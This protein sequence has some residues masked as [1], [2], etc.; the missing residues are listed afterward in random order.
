MIVFDDITKVYARQLFRKKPYAIWNLS[1]NL[2]EGQTLGLIGANGA[3]KSTA[4]RLIMDFIRP[5]SGSITVRGKQPCDEATRQDIGYLPEIASFPSNLCLLDLIRF[6]AGTCGIK[7]NEMRE[8][9]EALM[10]QLGL[11]EHRRKRLHTYSKGMQQ[12]ANFVLALMNDPKL[13]ILDEPMSGLDPLGRGLIIDLIEK[14]K[15]QGKTILFCSH[16][17]GDVDRLADNLLVLHKGKELFSGFPAEFVRKEKTTNIEEAY[18]SLIKR[19]GESEH[20][21]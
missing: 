19:A 6:T 15:Q 18:L 11:F 13:L 14:L 3:G 17:L 16:I 10:Q 1:F 20:V 2:D 12:R 21:A 9:G 8:R 5:T 4:I 7:K